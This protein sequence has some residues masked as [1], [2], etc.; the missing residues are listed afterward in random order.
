VGLDELAALA[1]VDPLTFDDFRCGRVDLSLDAFE[2]V[3]RRVG[4]VL[5]RAA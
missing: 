1:G 3:A 4:L 2:L 5:V